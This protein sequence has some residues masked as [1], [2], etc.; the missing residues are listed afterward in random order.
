MSPPQTQ[1]ASVS[2]T[3][4]GWLRQITKTWEAP[5]RRQLREIDTIASDAMRA[6]GPLTDADVYESHELHHLGYQG[7]VVIGH[8]LTF[9]PTRPSSA[10]PRSYLPTSSELFVTQ[11]IGVWPPSVYDRDLVAEVIG[12]FQGEREHKIADRLTA[13][14]SISATDEQDPMDEG[15][16]RLA[17]SFINQR[18]RQINT[19][20]AELPN[21]VGVGYPAI[22]LTGHGE[23]QLLWETEDL[24]VSIIITCLLDGQVRLDIHEDEHDQSL[25]LSRDDAM[26]YS[27]SL[28][29]KIR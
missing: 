13:L 17:L 8:I 10:R 28:L 15:S 1:E 9:P 27:E 20:P 21:V 23:I 22:W 5:S 14:R 24:R 6:T 2:T 26:V 19:E 29:S 11:D 4:D 18:R 7:E 16:L 12:Y 25:V 3:V